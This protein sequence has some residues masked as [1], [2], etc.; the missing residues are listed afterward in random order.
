MFYYRKLALVSFLIRIQ[1]DLFDLD[2]SKRS[3]P[4]EF[5]F[6]SPILV[7]GINYVNVPYFFKS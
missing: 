5:R 3:D 7:K 2:P 6:G 4:F 1:T